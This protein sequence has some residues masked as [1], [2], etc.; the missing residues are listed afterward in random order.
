MSEGVEVRGQCLLQECGPSGLGSLTRP[1][2][3][4]GQEQD[5][6]WK[7]QETRP[8]SESL[9]LCTVEDD[10]RQPEQE[11][12]RAAGRLQTGGGRQVGHK[13]VRQRR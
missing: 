3:L 1:V 2:E 13:L 10:G 11:R 8:R 4:M 5:P 7:S 12:R 9:Q 6:L